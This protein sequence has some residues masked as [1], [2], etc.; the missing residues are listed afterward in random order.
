M[1]NKK[2]GW[3]LLKKARKAVSEG[4]MEQR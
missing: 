3:I 1:Q 2:A 4:Q